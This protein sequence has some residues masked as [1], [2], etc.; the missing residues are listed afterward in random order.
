[1]EALLRYFNYW[2]FF[3]LYGVFYS[4]LVPLSMGEA[5]PHGI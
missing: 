5:L 2:L 4:V 3:T 1:M